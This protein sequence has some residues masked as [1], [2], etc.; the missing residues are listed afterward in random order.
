MIPNSDP[1]IHSYTRKGETKPQL[2]F[3]YKHV[4]ALGDGYRAKEY[5]TGPRPSVFDNGTVKADEKSDS[6]IMEA[7]NNKA[8]TRPTPTQ[9]IAPSKIMVSKKGD[10]IQLSRTGSREFNISEIN[11]PMLLDLGYTEDQAGEIFKLICK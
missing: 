10:I 7:F 5:Y 6:L 9:T 4:N 11:I 8:K 2:Y 1:F 3:V